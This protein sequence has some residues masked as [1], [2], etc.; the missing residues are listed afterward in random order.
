MKLNKTLMAVSL[1]ALGGAMTSCDSEWLEILPNT[2]DTIEVYYTND[3]KIQEALTAAYDPMLI[4]CLFSG[5]I[6]R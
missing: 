5:I 1:L 4:K 3:A 6:A 2:E